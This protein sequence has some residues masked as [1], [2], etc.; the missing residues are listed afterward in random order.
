MEPNN[1]WTTR[2]SIT[3][4]NKEINTCET[5]NCACLKCHPLDDILN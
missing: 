2:Y 1:N 4:T 3:E 5:G